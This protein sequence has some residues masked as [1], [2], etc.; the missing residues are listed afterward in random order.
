ME[1]VL[2]NCNV[3]ADYN[4]SMQFSV[5]IIPTPAP[6]VDPSFD[7]IIKQVI[8][9]C[10]IRNNNNNRLLLRKCCRD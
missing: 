8:S 7:S 9:E 10:S 3:S 1:E 5:S 6:T 4:E 2:I